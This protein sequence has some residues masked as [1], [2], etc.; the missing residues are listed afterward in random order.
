MFKIASIILVLILEEFAV[1]FKKGLFLFFLLACFLISFSEKSF[2]DDYY[3]FIYEVLDEYSKEGKNRPYDYKIWQ[4]FGKREQKVNEVGFK[5][6][7]A[8]KFP[9]NVSFIVQQGRKSTQITNAQAEYSNGTIRI[10]KGLFYYIE[11]DDELAAILAHELAHIHQQ[12]TGFWLWKRV[13]MFFAPKYYEHDAD[14]RGIDYMV[15][16][17]YNPVAMITL[18]NKFAGEQ[19]LFSKYILFYKSFFRLWG[20][21]FY[22]PQ[23]THPVSSKRMLK[24]YRHIQTHYPRFLQENNGDLYFINFLINSEKNKD[25]KQ[26]KDKYNLSAPSCYEDL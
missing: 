22:I 14:I 11:S 7:N 5:L 6:L 23:N 24:M 4:R 16:A 25:V 8:N 1:F 18:F 17:G 12:S 19:S 3:D 20:Y 9:R 15:E 10:F 21:I 13:K 2:A 26:V